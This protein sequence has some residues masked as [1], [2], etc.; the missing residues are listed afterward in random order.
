MTPATTQSLTFE[1]EGNAGNTDENFREF[2]A[3]ENF[4]RRGWLEDSI[5]AG[6]KL[7]LIAN[8][9]G[10]DHAR[11]AIDARIEYRAARLQ[12]VGEDAISRNF[13]A[14]SLVEDD[15]GGGAVELA[16]DHI[17][18]DDFRP[19]DRALAVERFAARDHDRA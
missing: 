1:S 8:P 11:L 19:R 2:F 14:V 7:G 9:A 12:R 15:G 13:V 3:I 6:R 10:N 18:L 4:R 17:P 5:C 16:R